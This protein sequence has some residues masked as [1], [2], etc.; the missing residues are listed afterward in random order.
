MKKIIKNLLDNYLLVYIDRLLKRPNIDN[1]LI[2]VSSKQIRRAGDYI[3]KLLGSTNSRT[4]KK[5]GNFESFLSKGE[6]Q[7]AG[8][9]RMWCVSEN[10]ICNQIETN[11]NYFI[12]L[13]NS[14]EADEEIQEIVKIF[15][16]F[17]LIVDDK[18]LL[19]T[20]YVAV[21][22]GTTKRGNSYKAP[23]HF[24]RKKGLIPKGSWPEYK[25]WGELYYPSGGTWI[26]GNRVPAKLLEQGGKLT[27]F[28]DITYEWVAPRDFDKVMERGT[29]GTSCYA[30]LHPVNGIY[31]RV[32]YSKNHA[33]TK[34]KKKEPTFQ[35]IG[36]SYQPF[37]KKLA[38]NY[39]LGYGMLLSFGIKKPFNVF[40]EKEITQVKK[41]RGWDYVVL[42]EN[43]KDFDKGI[44]KLNED[45][46][47]KVTNN[48][49]VDKWVEGLK[50]G[51][52]IEGVN[53]DFFSKL[54]T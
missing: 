38:L 13:V 47:E 45:N 21:G 10:G 49:A 33:I 11:F 30:W 25:T 31:K 46:L 51:N 34:I 42:V 54:I 23:A 24:I 3:H 16:H 52:K 9:E 37:V 8:F 44:Y 39:D 48:S 19:D 53:A 43:Y 36:D 41:N 6:Q 4:I 7:N 15:R 40:N 17:G 26:N 32:S 50:D 20:A 27:E 2:E 35:K 29:F 1:G 28:I 22:S 5:D 12:N 14:D 18:C